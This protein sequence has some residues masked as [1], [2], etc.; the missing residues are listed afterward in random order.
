VDCTL[1]PDAWEKEKDLLLLTG[2]ELSFLG[3][4]ARRLTLP[5]L[6]E[7]RDGDVI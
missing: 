3:C 7:E 4:L 6:L 1:D 2:I 5:R